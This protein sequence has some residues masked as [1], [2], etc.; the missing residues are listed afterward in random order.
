MNLRSFCNAG[1]KVDFKGKKNEFANNFGHVDVVHGRHL[2][3]GHVVHWVGILKQEYYLAVTVCHLSIR[4][5][6]ESK[7]AK[8][9]EIH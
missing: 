7:L 5:T 9:T 8:V 3:Q 4:S 6:A 2:N 1:S